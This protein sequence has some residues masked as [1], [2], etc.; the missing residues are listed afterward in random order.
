MPTF[1]GR[2]ATRV[3]YADTADIDAGIRLLSAM[4]TLPTLLACL[5]AC[6]LACLPACLLACL[7]A[8]LLAC[9]PA[10]LLACWR[11]PGPHPGP[12]RKGQRLRSV[13]KQIFF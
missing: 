1:N 2:Y 6:L 3:G 9:W 7:P 11:R 13:R 8:C 5:P 10:G 12:G 4:P